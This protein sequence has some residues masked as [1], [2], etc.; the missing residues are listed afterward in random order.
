MS[1]PFRIAVVDD[2]PTARQTLAFFLDDPRYRI[3]EFDN[4][5]ALLAAP[6]PPPSLVLL[7]VEM[8][9][10]D[11]IETCR[12]L[13]AGGNVQTLV[14]FI[15]AHDDLDT[16]LAAYDAGG[17]DYMLKP[18]T[19]AELVRKVRAA[20]QL[21]RQR[22]GMAMEADFARQ[23]AFTAMSSLGETGTVL[24]CLRSAFGCGSAAELAR[25][26]DAAGRELGTDLLLTLRG[27]RDAQHFAGGR[28]C[29]PIQQSILEY[30]AG[31]GRIVQA[32]DSLIVNYPLTTLVATGLPLADPARLGRLRDH[33]AVLA[34]GADVRLA[35]LDAERCRLAQAAS[36]IAAAAELSQTL[37]EIERAREAHRIGAIAIGDDYLEEL[38]QAFLHLGLSEAQEKAL[39]E[40]AQAAIGRTTKLLE[41]DLAL[42]SRLQP[43]VSRLH[44]AM[45]GA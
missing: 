13:R 21:Q 4:G 33:L 32:R 5:E 15:S 26:L 11:G 42:A 3:A 31:K 28:E 45:H 16:R 25:T 40:M 39:I 35:A 27:G 30:A 36:V 10:P 29:S 1:E 8:P 20:E 22:Q 23:T 34:E 41:D 2:D 14:V 17:N 18:Y 24:A 9:P 19:E 38:E 6:E 12:R 44:D 43:V 7:D 37:E